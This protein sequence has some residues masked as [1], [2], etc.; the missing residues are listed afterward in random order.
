MRCGLG[1][2]APSSGPLC[3]S[4]DDGFFLL[5]NADFVGCDDRT[6]TEGCASLEDAARLISTKPRRHDVA[7]AWRDGDTLVTI[8]VFATNE[9][10]NK[11]IVIQVG[12][13]QLGAKWSTG[14]ELIVYAKDTGHR[15]R[16]SILIALEV[17]QLV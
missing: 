8:P 1:T 3:A 11:D 10:C 17:S 13:N 15:S 5:H 6:T 2:G 7:Y 16:G 14:S 4:C 9:M 12:I